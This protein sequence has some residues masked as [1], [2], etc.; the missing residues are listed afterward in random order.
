MKFDSDFIERV[1]DANDIVD[2]IG[3]FTQLKPSGANMNGLCPFPDHREKSPSFSVSQSKQVYY[4]FGCKKAGNIYSFVEQI[5]GLSFPE[6]VEYLANRAGIP[7]PKDSRENSPQRNANDVKK[8]MQ[9]RI[10]ELAS[11]LFHASLKNAPAS[12]SIHSYI[13][14]RGLK[15][16][17]IE[18]FRIGYTP[19][20]WDQ[21]TRVFETKG[22]P[23]ER[24]AEIGLVKM[25]AKGQAGYFDIF[26]NRL[27]FPIW[28]VS[29]Q[30]IGFGGRA[31][32][33]D[34][35]KYLNSPDAEI[36]HKGH[37][38][39]GLHET[40]KFIRAQDQAI[41]VE[42]YMDFLALYQA[43]FQ[44]VVATLGT[45]LTAD[46]ARLLKRYTKNVVVLFDGDEAGQAAAERSAPILLSHGLYPRALVLPERQDPDEFLQSSGVEALS[47]LLKAAPELFSV[48]IQRRLKGHQGTNSEKVALLDVFAPLIVSSPDERLR[49][50]YTLELAEWLGLERGWVQAAIKKGATGSG[51][52]S[53]PRNETRSQPPAP[54][55]ARVREQENDGETGSLI[56]IGNPPRAELELLNLALMQKEY[57]D[58]ILASNIVSHFHDQGIKDIFALIERHYRQMPTDFDNLTGFLSS[59]VKPPSTVSLHLDKPFSEISR[60]GAKKLILDCSRK[61]RE[62]FLRVKHKEIASHLRGLRSADQMD[63]LE[64]IMNIQRDRHALKNDPEP[65]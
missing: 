37:V 24:A 58:E 50:L 62:A 52:K 60:E 16:E 44:N 45:A 8:K 47:G 63:Q 7:I 3:Q 55:T 56:V 46:H 39:Y 43:G 38:F 21:L 14:G 15:P 27:M 54:V 30:V 36:F 11:Q 33:N 25:R 19:D 6:A 65:N 32:S 28:S 4:C 48:L 51:S 10:A 64:Q 23:L 57:L 5:Q 34:P 17:T 12:H 29:G 42:G 2:I 22:V 40:A 20:S 35:P 41:V 18:K 61:I 26:R 9:L 49:D 53:V 31:L 59:R 1:R 13:Q